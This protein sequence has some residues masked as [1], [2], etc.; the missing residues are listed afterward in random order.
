MAKVIGFDPKAIK[1][2]TCTKCYAI[3]EYNIR[4]VLPNGKTDEGV[5]IKGLIC[6]SCGDFHRTNP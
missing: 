5:P 4:E 6:P 2:F 1:T 3:V